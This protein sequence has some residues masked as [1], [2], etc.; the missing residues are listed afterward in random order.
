MS[1]TKD[2]SLTVAIPTYGREGVLIET[3]NYLLKLEPRCF[4]ILVLD[5]TPNH[6]AET[7][8][9]LSSLH[10]EE[11][12]QWIKLTEPSIPKAMNKALLEASCSIVLFLD[13]DIVPSKDLFSTHIAAHKTCGLVAGQVLQ[14]GQREIELQPGEHFQFNAASPRLIREFMGGNFSVDVEKATQIGGFDENFIGAAYRFEAEFA[15]RFTSR[16]GD[17]RFEPKAGV[18]HLAFKSGGTRGHGHHLTTS[19]PTHSFGEYYYLM[20][21]RPRY[22]RWKFILRP[23]R[24]IKTKHHLKKPWFIVPTLVA[25]VHGMCL[26]I[27]AASKGPKYVKC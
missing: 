7:I 6:E 15:H 17:I 9:A 2:T 16:F 27:V 14:P 19:R 12:I 26:A 18:H 4:E 11:S 10:A 22:W 24:S 21:V 13:D 5:Q 1:T 20:R 8:V 25:E 3:I 23:L